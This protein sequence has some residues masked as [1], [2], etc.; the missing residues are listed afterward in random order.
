MFLL[1]ALGIWSSFKEFTWLFVVLKK[2]QISSVCLLVLT[3][4]GMFSG[5]A[6]PARKKTPPEP[7][8]NT[9]PLAKKDDAALW[10]QSLGKILLVNPEMGFVLVD[11]GTAP[12]PQNGAPLRAYAGG[13]VSGELVVSS[14]QR[15]PF[16]IGDIVSGAPKVG[17]SVV[18]MPA[19]SGAVAK[20][21]PKEPVSLRRYLPEPLPENDSPPEYLPN[22]LKEDSKGRAVFPGTAG[23]VRASE[24]A[25]S[26]GGASV[27]R[28]SAEPLPSG[29]SPAVVLPRTQ[30]EASEAPARGGEIIPG[31]PV[32]RKKGE[33]Q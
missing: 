13:A 15:R 23:S 8:E 9:A 10:Q 4:G 3:L 33:S 6:T 26:A 32:S 25:A 29:A 24:T 20:L 2:F 27:Q 7:P 17:D 28:G 19:R 22:L 16:L 5:C 18:L 12:A 11:I 21:P 1:N 14:Y 30:G 31:V